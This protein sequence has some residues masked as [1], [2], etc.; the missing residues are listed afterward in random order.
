MKQNGGEGSSPHMFDEA[1]AAFREPR[2]RA[3]QTRVTRPVRQR[4]CELQRGAKHPP[5]P[6]LEVLF[7][8]VGRESSEFRCMT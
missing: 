4:P 1:S 7:A 3:E 8:R 5:V 6:S 2:A